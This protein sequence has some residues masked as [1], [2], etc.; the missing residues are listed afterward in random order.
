MGLDE[1]HPDVTFMW[2]NDPDGTA[3]A[4]GIGAE[5]TLKS[6]ALVDAGIGRIEDTLQA[7][8]LLDRANI[9][10]T[11]DHGFSTHTRELRL[12][13]LVDPSRG[14]C[15]TARRTSSLS[16]GAVYFRSGR[17]AAR[18][19][20]IVAALQ[21]RPEVG[22]IFTRPRRGGGAEGVVPG[23]LSFDVARWNHPRVGRHPGVGELDPRD[24]TTPASPGK[25]TRRRRGRARHVEPVRHPQHADCRRSGFSRARRQRRADRQRR[26]RADAAAAARDAAG[27]ER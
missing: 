20:A 12:A 11:S 23:T 17:D 2:L 10:V 25:T 21:Q 1:L 13:A 18:V 6:L 16:E 27:A 19:A 14:R 3:H 26:H 15:P 7:R 9:I 5:L 8:G 4:N 24:A 22:A